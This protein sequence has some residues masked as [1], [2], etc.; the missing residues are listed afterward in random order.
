VR[1]RGQATLNVRLMRRLVRAELAEREGR[2]G[3]ALAELR[4]GQ[5]R[6]AGMTLPLAEAV[7]AH[8]VL[9]DRT[10]IGRLILLP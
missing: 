8:Q 4:A 5:L 6:T 9:E 10:V 7:R 3:A 2:P 1:R